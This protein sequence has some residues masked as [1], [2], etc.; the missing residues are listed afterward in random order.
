MDPASLF[1]FLNTS[2]SLI[3]NLVVT[4]VMALMVEVICEHFLAP[5]FALQVEFLQY[6]TK[7]KL[8]VCG[9]WGAT[10]LL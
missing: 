2:F 7:K 3:H 4:D 1:F 10:V 8:V 9:F 5:I 6:F